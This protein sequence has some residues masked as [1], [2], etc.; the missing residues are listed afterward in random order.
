MAEMRSRALRDGTPLAF[1]LCRHQRNR[2][3]QWSTEMVQKAPAAPNG[4]AAAGSGRGPIAVNLKGA[5][6]TAF[7]IR[8]VADPTLC[9]TVPR[10]FGL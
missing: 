3:Q 10:V 7:R 8:S 6:A 4:N 9:V 1:A 2:H 5:T